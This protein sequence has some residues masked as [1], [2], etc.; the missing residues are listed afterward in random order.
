MKVVL[1]LVKSFSGPP[2]PGS[3]YEG[4]WP[5]LSD[6]AG[7]SLRRDRV[8]EVLEAVEDVHRAVLDAVFVPRDEAPRD[9]SVVRVLPV[10][11]ELRGR[12]VQTLDAAL[13]DRAVVAEPDRAGDHE[14]V[15][16]EDVLLDQGHSSVAAP[17]S[18][19]SG[20]TPVATS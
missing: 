1:R 5:R 20:Q 17:C 6:P 16:G 10:G 4:P 2:D 14:D 3:R 11:I 15:C 12:R 18:V 8:A 9:S 13:R 7:V 19:M